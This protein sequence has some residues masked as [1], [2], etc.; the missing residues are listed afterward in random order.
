MNITWKKLTPNLMVEDVRN[1]VQYYTGTLGFA[2]RMAVAKGT[3]KIVETLDDAEDY[4]YAQVA[5][6]SVEIMF[7]EKKSLLEDLPGIETSNIGG[8]VSFYF[9]VEH[10]DDM[11]KALKDKVDIVKEL[12]TTWYGMREFYIRDCNGYILGFAEQA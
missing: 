10:V 11:Y 12:A 9:E 2:L 7:Q 8:S 4:V 1:A 3:H 5:S 6:N